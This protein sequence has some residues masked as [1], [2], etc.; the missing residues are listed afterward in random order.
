MTSGRFILSRDKEF[1]ACQPNGP[2]FLISRFSRRFRVLERMAGGAGKC[3]RLLG[4][5]RVPSSRFCLMTTILWSRMVERR[6]AMTRVSWCSAEASWTRSFDHVQEEVASP[7]GGWGRPE[8]GRVAC[9]GA[10][11]EM[12]PFPTRNIALKQPEELW[13]GGP[14]AVDLA[15]VPGCRAYI[16]GIAPLKR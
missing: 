13:A 14:A 3:P 16:F 1:T 12:A 5:P 8:D 7:G 10:L 2:W 15:W 11:P 9:V 4:V 6:W